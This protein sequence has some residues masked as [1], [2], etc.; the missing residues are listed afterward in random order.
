MKRKILL[1]ICLVAAGAMCAIAGTTTNAWYSAEPPGAFSDDYYDGSP[2]ITKHPCEIFDMR[3]IQLTDAQ[4]LPT[5]AFK[6]DIITNFGDQAH[7]ATYDTNNYTDT[8]GGSITMGQVPAGELYI[9]VKNKVVGT[10]A[11]IRYAFALE[12]RTYGTDGWSKAWADRVTTALGITPAN[13]VAGTLY[14]G[15]KFAT[16]TWEDYANNFNELPEMSL[17]RALD[18]LQLSKKAGY[19]T[20]RDDDNSYPTTIVSQTT[21][22]TG[23]SA[24]WVQVGANSW[25]QAF[26]DAWGGDGWNTKYNAAQGYW[27]GTFTLPGF[28]PTTQYIDVWW[29]MGCGNDGVLVAPNPS[30]FTTPI[31]LPGSLALCAIGLGFVGVVRRLRRRA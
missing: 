18:D 19:P 11:E 17:A 31:P 6:F 27:T 14:G 3:L 30:S 21:S 23:G 13:V 9:N 26:K 8:I 15:V 29:A 12:S 2:D 25:T 28:D 24:Q 20:T 5:A 10:E 16:G 4:G 1:A 7:R 22:Y